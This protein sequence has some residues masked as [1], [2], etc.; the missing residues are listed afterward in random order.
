M[1]YKEKLLN[2]KWQKK[3]LEILSRDN[4]RCTFCGDSEKTLHVHHLH[5]NG[6]D[7]WEIENK[8]LITLCDVCHKDESFDLKESSDNLINTLKSKGFT[9]YDFNYLSEAFKNTNLNF[10]SKI[11]LF[12]NLFNKIEEEKTLDKLEHDC[13]NINIKNINFNF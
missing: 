12:L 3:R 9:S 13:N 6:K 2:P 4:F 1:N 7:P 8:L 11:Y 5:Y 10:E